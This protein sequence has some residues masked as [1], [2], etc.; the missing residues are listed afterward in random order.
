MRTGFYLQVLQ[1]GTVQAGDTWQ[2]KSRPN[3]WLTLHVV[4]ASYY[5]IAAPGVVER[6]LATPE[7]AE[8]WRR[9]F[10]EKSKVA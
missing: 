9:M 5:Q 10:S 4:S 3:P 7:L 6:I 2:L 1:S 8:G